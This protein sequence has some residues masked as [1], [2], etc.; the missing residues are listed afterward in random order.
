MIA[1]YIILAASPILLLIALAFVSLIAWGIRRGE[2]RTSPE[3]RL[4]RLTRR[5]IGVGFRV[6]DEAMD[7]D[8][9]KRDA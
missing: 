4:D 1:F 2:R 3:N 8:E 9:V 6:I 7:E 5:V